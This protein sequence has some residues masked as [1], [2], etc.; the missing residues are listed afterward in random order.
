[1]LLFGMTYKALQQ[2]FNSIRLPINMNT[3]VERKNQ[4]QFKSFEVEVPFV[5]SSSG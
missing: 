1:M 2:N 3:T 5:G 4:G